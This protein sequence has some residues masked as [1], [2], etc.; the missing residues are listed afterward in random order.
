MQKFSSMKFLNIIL[1]LATF[2]LLGLSLSTAWWY[3]FWVFEIL[4]AAYLWFAGTTL[5]L[6]S[7]FLLVKSL[8]RKR[9]LL[10]V[11]TIA[12]V[13]YAQSILG[14]YVPNFSQPQSSRISVTV[15]TYNV[16]YQLWNVAA[17]EQ[18]VRAHPSDILGLVEPF[19]EQAADLWRRTQDVYPYYYRATGGNLSLFSRYRMIEA[20]TDNLNSSHHSLFAT[21]DIQGKPV[22]VIVLR[23]PAPLTINH[24]NRR[25][26][27]LR[28]V[29]DYAKQ[30]SSSLIVM[31]DFNTTSWSLFLRE[32]VQ[33]S[34]LHNASLGHGLHPTWYYA[35]YSKIFASTHWL[36]QLIK[37]PIDHIFLSDDIQVDQFVAGP[38]GVS[39]HRSLISK[40]RV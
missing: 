17:V 34:K 14:W 26:Q 25:N 37:I 5:L 6:F 12:L 9:K 36:F 2:L 31:G 30:Q 40:I 28:S 39:D 22:Q 27:V 18:L 33:R 20:R 8:R 32:F 21:L 35:T 15:M 29:A 10:V 4:G 13:F 11:L 24:F 23:P 19:K 7:I 38:S 16:N 1:W 3:K